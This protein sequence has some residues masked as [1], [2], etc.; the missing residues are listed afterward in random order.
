M[1]GLW[2]CLMCSISFF[3]LGK[4][5]LQPAVEQSSTFPAHM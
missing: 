2:C 5:L 1:L 4:E 3:M